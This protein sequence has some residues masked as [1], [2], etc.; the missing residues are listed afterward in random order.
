M[1]NWRRV[2]SPRNLNREKPNGKW[3]QMLHALMEG[4]KRAP[5]KEK[6]APTPSGRLLRVQDK[7]VTKVDEG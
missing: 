1:A 3:N 2:A 4:R 5:G 6:I 7:K